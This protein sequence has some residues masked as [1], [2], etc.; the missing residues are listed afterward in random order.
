MNEDHDITLPLNYFA[1]PYQEPFWDAMIRGHKRAVLVW[2][3]RAGKEKTCWNYLIMQAIK[4]AGIYYYFF[5]TFSQ[6]RKILWDGV[7]KSGFR[8]L[9]HIPKQLIEGVPNSNEMKIRLKNGSLIQIIGTNNIDSI[10]GT[11][12][13]GCVFTEY[14]LQDPRAWDFMRPILAENGGWAVF[15]FTPRGHNFAYDLYTMAHRSP[16]WFCQVLTVDDTGVLTP[17]DIQRELDEGMSEDLVRQEYYCSFEQGVAG[18]Y[19]GSYLQQAREDGRIT[20]LPVEE[21]A[22]VD[23][24]WDLGVSDSTAILFAQ[25]CGPWIHLVDMYT[26]EGEGLQHYVNVLRSKERER[27]FLYGTHWAPHDIQVRDFSAGAKT[28]LQIA[29]EMGIHFQI[30]P[31]IPIIDGIEHGRALWRKLKIDAKKCQY[32]CKCM[33]NYHKR[34]NESLNCYSE[35]PVHD[36]S[37]HVADS[38][39][40]MAVALSSERSASRMSEED[41]MNMERAHAYRW[42]R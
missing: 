39:R 23:T 1:R 16:E 27:G 31:N 3:R 35:T 38:Y 8:L 33:D 4:R 37:S 28:R 11:N 2:H 22:L 18:S 13:I 12:P 42:K 32:F 5:P 10:V 36:W 19:Y 6:G 9:H 24:F 40:Y 15:N 20:E 17:S 34:F 29:R 7:D 26:A 41:A 30:V 14:S 21:H 25:R